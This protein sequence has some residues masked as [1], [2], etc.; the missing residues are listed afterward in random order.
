[1]DFNP[2]GNRYNRLL[3]KVIK[4]TSLKAASPPPGTAAGAFMQEV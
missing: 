3:A 4:N 2:S 1:M